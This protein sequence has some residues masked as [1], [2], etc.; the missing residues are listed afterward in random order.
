MEPV[1]PILVSGLEV[2]VIHKFVLPI[3]DEVAIMMPESAKILHVADQRGRLCLW[4][5]VD[6]ERPKVRRRFA[7]IGTGYPFP[8]ELVGIY[9]ETAMMAA[10]GLVW[11]VFDRGESR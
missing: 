11:H 8:P 6:P 5:I 2:R 7:I 9:I 1:R 4:A 10:S 3:T